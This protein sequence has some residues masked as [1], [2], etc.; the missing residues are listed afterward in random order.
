MPPRPR[1]VIWITSDH[2]RYDCIAAH[3]NDEVHTPNLDRLVAGGVSYDHCYGQNPLCMPSRC[4]FMTGLYPQQTGVTCNGHCLPPDFAPTIARA[5]SAGNYQTA[6]IGKLHFQPHEDSDLDPRPRHDYGFDVLWQ[7][8]EPGNYEDAYMNWLRTEYPQF[9]ELFRVPRPNAPA[10]VEEATGRVLDAPWQASFSGWVA[11]Q[12]C[13]YLLGHWGPREGNHFVH[14]GIYAPHPPLNP[15]REMMAPYEGR[16][17]T[18]PPRS[19][20]EAA[21]KP[22]PLRGMLA[23]CRGWDDER[24]ESYRRHFYAMVTGVDL[25][26]GQVLEQLEQAGQLDET[27]IVFGAD[28]GDMCG[29]HGMVTKQASFYDQLMRLPLVLHWPAG[30]GRRPMRVT[31]L[32]EMVDVLPTL[33]ELAGC[34]VPACMVGRS[35]AEAL[36]AGRQPETRED[37]IAFD[38]PGHMM[39]RTATHKYIRYADGGEVLYDLSEQPAETVNR[40]ADAGCADMLAEMRLR[41]L[42]RAIHA[43]RSPLPLRYRY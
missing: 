40:A 11:E 5:F 29:D 31:G 3:G 23:M 16:R 1:H 33:L 37:V 14:M 13:R 6:Q 22:S 39:L 42:D 2:M 41:L 36:L 25:A 18:V 21:D 20:D 35:H 12:T 4:S 24:F 17:V 7:A 38:G 9:V 27:L 32:T 15:T 28:H 26:V 30:L 43:S 34:N 19:A 10:R 8:E